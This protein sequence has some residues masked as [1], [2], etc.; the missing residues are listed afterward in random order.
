MGG[1][2]PDDWI[3]YRGR[4]LIRET[5]PGAWVQLTDLLTTPVTI[6]FRGQ[7]VQLVVTHQVLLDLERRTKLD[8]LSDALLTTNLTASL[9]R[10]ILHVLL[11]RSHPDCTLRE[12]GTLFKPEIV[13][14]IRA[15]IIEAFAASM[16]LPRE[17]DSDARD[18][19][20]PG[21]DDSNKEDM[22][23]TWPD[24]WSEARYNLHLTEQEW[25][26]MTPRMVQALNARRLDDIYWIELMF[27]QVSADI[28]NHSF[29]RASTPFKATDFLLHRRRQAKPGGGESGMVTG[30]ELAAIMSSTIKTHNKRL[31]LAVQ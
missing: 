16:P 5:L 21:E 1:R 7:Q 24:L 17:D 29:S 20:D 26:G 9:L 15:L 27:G 4:R 6:L 10:N 30:D 14:E 19:D 8:L 22:P 12:V 18:E 2:F 3:R 25:L 23:Q 13:G 31:N 28:R 11:T